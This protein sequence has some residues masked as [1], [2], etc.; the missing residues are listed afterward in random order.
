MQTPTQFKRGK[1]NRGGREG[2]GKESRNHW[3]DGE[4]GT[5]VLHT[6]KKEEVKC[7][8]YKGGKG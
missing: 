5:C 3:N 4:G 8:S 7:L 1:S 2:A 6:I